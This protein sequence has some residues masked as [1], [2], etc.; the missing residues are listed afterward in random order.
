M[1]VW[2]KGIWTAKSFCLP[3]LNAYL[4]SVGSN[5]SHGANFATAG[6]T[7]RPQNTTKSQSGYSPISLDVQFQQFRDF[8]TRSKFVRER[9]TVHITSTCCICNCKFKSQY[10]K[11]ASSKVLRIQIETPNFF[12]PTFNH[13]RNILLFMILDSLE[14]KFIYLA[15]F[16]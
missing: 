11:L 7:V 16:T 1:N 13:Y 6:S 14:I 4:D 5:F 3:Y 8:K 12:I 15:K 2:W 10:H 9:G